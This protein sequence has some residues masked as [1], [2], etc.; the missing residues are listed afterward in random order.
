M[1]KILKLTC[2]PAFHTGAGFILLSESQCQTVGTLVSDKA[3][4]S[5]I[6][7]CELCEALSKF[8]SKAV[9]SVNEVLTP[10]LA[11]ATG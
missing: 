7:W 10:N 2:F 1:D 4:F 8:F 11:V 5:A 3:I 6:W 9:Y